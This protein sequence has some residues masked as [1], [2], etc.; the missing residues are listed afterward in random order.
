MPGL[1]LGAGAQVRT[2]AQAQ[3]GNANPATSSAYAAGYG[4]GSDGGSASAA[5]LAALLP[6][7][8]AGIGF[9]FGVACFAA[10]IFMYQ[11]LPE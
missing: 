6:N 8:A 2:T 10:L 1:T 5:G 7:D 4:V 3:Y 9:W 11:S